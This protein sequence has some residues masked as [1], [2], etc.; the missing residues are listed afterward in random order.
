MAC[1]RAIGVCLACAW[2]VGCGGGEPLGPLTESVIVDVVTALSAPADRLVAVDFRDHESVTLE[3]GTP[4]RDLWRDMLD[5]AR[6]NSRPSY[7]EIAPATRRV[8]DVEIPYVSPVVEVREVAEGVEVLLVY[9]AAI[10]V[11]RLEQP[12]YQAMLAILRDAVTSGASVVLTE[13]DGLGVVDVRPDTFSGA[14]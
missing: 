8:E 6:E 5:H 10:H 9:S 14:G 1:S 2:L 11:L 4:I 12:G 13:K 7:V 3:V